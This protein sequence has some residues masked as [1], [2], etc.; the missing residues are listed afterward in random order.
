MKHVLYI[1]RAL[2]GQDLAPLQGLLEIRG[3]GPTAPP[4]DRLVAEAAGATILAPTYIDRIDGALL[5]DLPTVKAVTSYGVGVNHIDLDACRKRGVLVT[6]TPGVLT[7]ATADHAV[8]L[9]LAAARRVAEGDRL[10]RA[11]GW[12]AVD[13]AFLLGTEVSGKTLGIVGFGRIGQAVARRATGFGMRL[14]YADPGEVEF[15]GARR[16]PLDDLLAQSDFVTLHTPLTPGTENLLC[17]ERIAKLKPGAV[18]VNTA[19]GQVVDDAAL[20]EALSSGRIAA[21]GLDVFRDE[22]RV[23]EAYLGLENVVLTPHIGSGSRETRAAMARLVFAEVERLA[24]GEPPRNPV[25]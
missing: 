9:L 13:P 11:G 12:K 3:G 22:P 8:A 10:I 6:N 7:D 19:R 15:P 17:R 14:L 25:P 23:P 20:A 16:V 21:A 1:V 5:D 24:R 4:R 18:V 2:P